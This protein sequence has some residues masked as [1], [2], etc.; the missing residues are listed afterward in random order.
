[1][2]FSSINIYLSP[3]RFLWHV[4]T[5]VLFPKHGQKHAHT[6]T[7]RLHS[8]EMARSLMVTCFTFWHMFINLDFL[9]KY[10]EK[11][12]S[13]IQIGIYYK[14]RIH[15]LW[16]QKYFLPEFMKCYPPCS[17]HVLYII[18]NKHHDN[19][20]LQILY[21]HFKHKEPSVERVN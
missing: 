13:N 17:V 7:Q 19:S 8:N 3:E 18:S 20:L 12:V 9:N 2:E 16:L 10:Y 5:C 4:L 6:Y 14:I 1:M 15:I 21:F 11:M